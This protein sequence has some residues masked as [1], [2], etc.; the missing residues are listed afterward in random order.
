MNEPFGPTVQAWQ[1]FYML[2]G[3]ASAT[4]I[5]L[6][7]IAAS[8]GTRLIEDKADPRIRTFVTPT[9]IYFSVVLLVSAL[10]NVPTLTRPVLLVVLAAAGLYAAVY[11]VSHLPRLRDI[12]QTESLENRAWLWNLLLPLFASLWLLGAALT[13][14]RFLAYGLEAAA[15]GVVLFLVIG[16]HNAWEVTLRLV[17]LSPS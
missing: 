7:F 8:L 17:S 12:N 15:F 6:I 9:V 1:S 2:L 14:P 3:G 13:L 10:M 16:L 5:G 11:S 4:L